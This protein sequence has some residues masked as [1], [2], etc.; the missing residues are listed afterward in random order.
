[1]IIRSGTRYKWDKRL[2]RTLDFWAQVSRYVALDIRLVGEEG[3]DIER[4][5]SLVRT[6]V[7][8]TLG[9]EL[10]TTRDS[11]TRDGVG[12]S[13]SA[14]ECLFGFIVTLEVG[15]HANGCD[16]MYSLRVVCTA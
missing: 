13:L 6:R 1:M 7:P 9:S 8:V 4:G 5:A 11:H 3:G 14:T 10:V 15:S 12:R 16:N 2:A